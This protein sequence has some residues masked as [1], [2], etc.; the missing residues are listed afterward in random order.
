MPR[1]DLTSSRH[2]KTLFSAVIVTP[3]CERNE[4]CLVGG[5][6]EIALRSCC[7]MGIALMLCYDNITIKTHVKILA[8]RIHI[9]ITYT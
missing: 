4:T 6:L 1:V 5:T 9:I 7:V 2:V 8:R 3:N